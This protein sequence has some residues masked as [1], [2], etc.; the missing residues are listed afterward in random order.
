MAKCDLRYICL[1]FA[2]KGVNRCAACDGI[3]RSGSS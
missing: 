1:G 3:G 2:K